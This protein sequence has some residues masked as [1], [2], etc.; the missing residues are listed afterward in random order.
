M[1]ADG[2]FLLVSDGLTLGVYLTL[3]NSSMVCVGNA[4][5]PEITHILPR[6]DGSFYLV[7][8]E[9]FEHVKLD[10]GW[11]ELLCNSTTLEEGLHEYRLQLDVAC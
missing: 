6:Y 5:F 8:V 2:N 7:T 11:G 1:F 9:G 10:I 4:S 3:A